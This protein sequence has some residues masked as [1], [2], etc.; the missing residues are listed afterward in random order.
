MLMVR[1]MR[2]R[3]RE[4]EWV[5]LLLLVRVVRVRVGVGVEEEVVQ[6]PGL[7]ARTPICLFRLLYLSD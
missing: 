1:L 3:R 6:P 4:V 2:R 7:L 5:A